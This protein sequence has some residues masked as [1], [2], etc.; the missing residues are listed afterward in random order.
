MGTTGMF[1]A[2]NRDPT[3]NV[4][5]LGLPLVLSSY[6]TPTLVQTVDACLG[7]SDV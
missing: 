6:Q 5:N 4:S 3:S 1:S 2:V 7:R